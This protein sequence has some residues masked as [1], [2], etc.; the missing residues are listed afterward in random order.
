MFRSGNIK[1][2]AISPASTSIIITIRVMSNIL[3]SFPGSVRVNLSDASPYIS[4]VIRN[5]MSKVLLTMEAS[6]KNSLFIISALELRC[7]KPL[8][9]KNTNATFFIFSMV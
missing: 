4:P 3:C 5:G 1:L 6:F 8:T 7:A 9:M 2:T